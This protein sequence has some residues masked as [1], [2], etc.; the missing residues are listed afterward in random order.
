M[1]RR[2]STVGIGVCSQCRQST[3]FTKADYSFSHAFGVQREYRWESECCNAP[4]L[5]EIDY[6]ERDY[7]DKWERDYDAYHRNRKEMR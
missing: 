1:K 3:A 2:Y 7:P 6:P 5:G 4:S